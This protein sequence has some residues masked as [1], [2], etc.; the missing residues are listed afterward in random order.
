MQII[1]YLEDDKCDNFLIS[2]VYM[3]RK[4]LDELNLESIKQNV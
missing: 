2:Q 3:N 4:T 1:V